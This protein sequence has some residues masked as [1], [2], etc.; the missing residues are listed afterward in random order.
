[1][2]SVQALHSHMFQST[3]AITDG[4]RKGWHH[5]SRYQLSR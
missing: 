5:A 2:T 3:P 4:R 1:L